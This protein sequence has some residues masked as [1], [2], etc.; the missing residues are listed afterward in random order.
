[1]ATHSITLAW[2]IAWTEEAN[3]D[4]CLFSECIVKTDIQTCS[5]VTGKNTEADSAHT[6]FPIYG[7]FVGEIQFQHCGFHDCFGF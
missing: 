3:S 4:L 6:F 2:E 7:V 5:Q 1:M